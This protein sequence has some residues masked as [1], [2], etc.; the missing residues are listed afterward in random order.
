MLGS[1][2]EGWRRRAAY[3][4]LAAVGPC[5]TRRRATSRVAPNRTVEMCRDET[6]SRLLGRPKTMAVSFGESVVSCNLCCVIIDV[7]PRCGSV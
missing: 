7:C 2:A 5:D 4:P 3:L 1:R 6:S